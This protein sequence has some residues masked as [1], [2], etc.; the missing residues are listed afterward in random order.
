LKK[1]VHIAKASGSIFKEVLTQCNLKTKSSLT[2]W[3]S[4][5]KIGAGKFFYCRLATLF[6]LDTTSK[7]TK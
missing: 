1:I 3:R 4:Q 6:C 7:S 5:T 2:Q